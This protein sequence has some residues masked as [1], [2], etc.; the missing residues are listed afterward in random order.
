MYK[1]IL[2]INNSPIINKRLLN[3]NK[4]ID[5]YKSNIDRLS[6][7]KDNITEN[8]LI[9]PKNMTFSLN[10][11]KTHIK[12]CYLCKGAYLLTKKL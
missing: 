2:S 3:I 9:T 4:E 6:G 1:E 12:K 5:A 7:E 11:R 8:G 10:K